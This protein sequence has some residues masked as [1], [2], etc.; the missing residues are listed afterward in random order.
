[1]D[2]K[3]MFEKDSKGIKNTEKCFLLYWPRQLK[4]EPACCRKIDTEVTAFLPTSS[5]GFLTSKFRSGEINELFHGKHGLW[6]EIF[7]ESFE[8]NI[9]LKKDNYWV[10]LLLSLKI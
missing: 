4:T 6:V 10:F 5:R 9:Q 1:M 8:D 7:N 3:I 2:D